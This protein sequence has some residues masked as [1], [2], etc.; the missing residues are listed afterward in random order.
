MPWVLCPQND[1]SPYEQSLTG[2]GEAQHNVSMVKVGTV[3]AG[4]WAYL[5]RSMCRTKTLLT[6]P[7]RRAE[8]LSSLYFINKALPRETAWVCL[9]NDAVRR[10]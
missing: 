5:M 7:E 3:Q 6:K 2:M 8:T 9:S 1:V 4:V 10:A